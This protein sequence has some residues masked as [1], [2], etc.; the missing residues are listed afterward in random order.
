M[1]F[2]TSQFDFWSLPSSA[3]RQRQTHSMV[4][5]FEKG[6]GR[7]EVFSCSKELGEAARFQLSTERCRWTLESTDVVS[8]A[9]ALDALLAPTI[10]NLR[11]RGRFVYGRI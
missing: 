10:A 7:G 11:E 9:E 6:D 1:A 8:V 3:S 4:V 2:E 5:V